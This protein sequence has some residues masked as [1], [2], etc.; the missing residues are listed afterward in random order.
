MEIVAVIVEEHF[1]GQWRRTGIG[2]EEGEKVAG[3]GHR[4]GGR[5]CRWHLGSGAH[6]NGLCGLGTA[7]AVRRHGFGGRASSRGIVEGCGSS[8]EK[9]SNVD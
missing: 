4:R 6:A 3:S 7:A 8:P 9:I 2:D 1:V 5:Y